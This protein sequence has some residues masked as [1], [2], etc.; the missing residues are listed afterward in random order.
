M[1]RFTRHLLILALLVSSLRAQAAEPEIATDATSELFGMTSKA[2]VDE[3]W[4]DVMVYGDWRMQCEVTHKKNY[5]LLD[6]STKI[7]MRGTEA[8]CLAKFDE[9]K[10]SA[11]LSPRKSEAVILLHG[12]LRSRETMIPLAKYFST[13]SDYEV[14]NVAYPSTRAAISDHAEALDEV[15]SHLDGVERIHFVG[16]SLGNLVVR[17]WMKDLLTDEDR[18]DTRVG[19]FV[20]LGPPNNGARIAQTLRDVPL[21]AMMIG[22]SGRQ[23]AL[24]WDELSTCLCTPSCEFGILA[25]K[26]VLS[27]PLIGDGDLIVGVEET[28][29]IGARDFRVLPLD[30]GALR[31]DPQVLD[32]TLAF[33]KH[34]HFESDEKREPLHDERR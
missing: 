26:P 31:R 19:R 10:L 3:P 25:G 8:E 24:E 32:M 34:G 18:I 1:S 2:L 5:R 22:R 16:H 12:L 29:L 4:T 11:N 27:N 20:M 7:V 30:H 23:L 6:P 15:I 17:H 21:F 14:V 13:N 33:L 9:I 28:K